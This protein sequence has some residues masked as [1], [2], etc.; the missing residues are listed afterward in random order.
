MLTSV[1]RLWE[2]DFGERLRWQAGTVPRMRRG[3]FDPLE[4]TDKTMWYV[5]RTMRGAILEVRQLPPD[6]AMA[7]GND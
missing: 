3:T 1:R 7:G 4:K 5:V 6:A 2:D